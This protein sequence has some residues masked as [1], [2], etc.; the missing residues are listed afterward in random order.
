M[1]VDIPQVP[2]PPSGAF[3]YCVTALKPG[4][5]VTSLVGNFM[6]SGTLNLIV[7]CGKWDRQGSCCWTPP[8]NANQVYLLGMTQEINTH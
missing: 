8:S 5:V 7:G 1:E 6:D 4:G 3:N 2:S